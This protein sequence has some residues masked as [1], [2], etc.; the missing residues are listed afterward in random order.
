[1]TNS[2]HCAGLPARI[3]RGFAPQPSDHAQSADPSTLSKEVDPEPARRSKGDARG[4]LVRHP[5]NGYGRRSMAVVVVVGCLAG[6]HSPF[7]I[8]SRLEVTDPEGGI[9]PHSRLIR[10][11]QLFA[12]KR[13]NNGRRWAHENC[14]LVPALPGLLSPG[15]QVIPWA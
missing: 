1:M 7:G 15:H 10:S 5:L 13:L 11:R 9:L 2:L 3:D 4:G 6:R 12:V 8:G 14:S